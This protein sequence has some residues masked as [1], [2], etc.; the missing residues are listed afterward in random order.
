MGFMFVEEWGGHTRNFS[1]KASVRVWEKLIFSS[2]AKSANHSG[3]ITFFL[4][5]LEWYFRLYAAKSI[6]I[7]A[8]VLLG[9]CF[10]MTSTGVATGKSFL[11]SPYHH[12]LCICSSPHELCAFN[13][14]ASNDNNIIR[15][16]VRFQRTEPT[17]NSY[18]NK[19]TKPH[20][21]CYFISIFG[22]VQITFT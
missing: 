20:Q 2:D 5:V 8:T 1:F 4:I 21:K 11:S 13:A 17:W 12:W 18:Q 22:G 6:P 16:E 7:R 15:P 10:C 14:H 3:M 9:Y 19:T